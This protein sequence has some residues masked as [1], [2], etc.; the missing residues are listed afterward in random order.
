MTT[1]QLMKDITAQY[2]YG[3][4]NAPENKVD[5]GLIRVSNI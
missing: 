3:T 2:L 5:E 4:T 1:S